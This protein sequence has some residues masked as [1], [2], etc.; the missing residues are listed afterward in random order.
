MSNISTLFGQ[1]FNAAEVEPS[2]PYSL[3]PR[4]RYV[5]SID[6]SAMKATKSGNG[7]YLE[8]RFRVLDG[9]HQD[10]TAYA[11]FNLVNNNTKAMEIAFREFSSLCRA[12]G[13]LQVADSSELHDR[14]LV[15]QVDLEIRKEGGK[16]VYGDDGQPRQNNVIKGYFS[17]NDGRRPGPSTPPHAPAPA[18]PRP[19]APMPP[20]AAQ[21]ATTAKPGAPAAP[22]KRSA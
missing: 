21:R 2:Q 5:V 7:E 6:D 9:E 20:P 15:I 4:G 17:I 10:A 11:R 16:I 22:W 19:A 13:V 8:C 1:A 18:A 14:P 12:V 3:L